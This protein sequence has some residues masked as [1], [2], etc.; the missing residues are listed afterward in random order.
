[1][2]NRTYGT[3]KTNDAKLMRIQRALPRI[4]T[5]KGLDMIAQGNALGIEQDQDKKQP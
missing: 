5:P 2:G 4:C 1:M 3:Y